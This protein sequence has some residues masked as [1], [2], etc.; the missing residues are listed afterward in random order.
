MA[1]LCQTGYRWLGYVKECIDVWDNVKQGIDA[2]D[3]VEPGIDG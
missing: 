2:W 1:G 3:N